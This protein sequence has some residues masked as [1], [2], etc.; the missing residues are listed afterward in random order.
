M[1]DLRGELD[2]WHVETG[3]LPAGVQAVTDFARRVVVID[4]RLTSAETRSALAHEVEHVRRGPVPDEPVLAAREESLVERAA[5]CR[6]IDLEPLGE[7][8]AWAHSYAEC[9]DE[10]HVDEALLRCR[11]EHL[12][13]CERAYLRGRLE[14]R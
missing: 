12:H 5:A 2:G 4:D 8:L 14:H 13:G 1:G 6:L 9:A 3:E 10:L 7:A 11:L